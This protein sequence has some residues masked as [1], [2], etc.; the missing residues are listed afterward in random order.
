[1]GSVAAVGTPDAYL[2]EGAE[3]EDLV[4]L[5]EQRRP[6]RTLFALLYAVIALLC[7]LFLPPQRGFE[8]LGVVAVLLFVVACQ[9]ELTLSSGWVGCQQ[10]AFMLMLFTLPLNAVPAL[11]C[12]SVVVAQMLK[13]EPISRLGAWIGCN[14]YA[15]PPV[16]VLALSGSSSQPAWS[17]WPTYALAFACQ[18]LFSSAVMYVQ[19]DFYGEHTTL[20]DLLMPTAVDLML[21]PIGLMAAVDGRSTPVAAAVTL[22]GV[23]GLLALLGREHAERRT[24]ADRAL[25]DPLTGLPNRALFSEELDACERRCKRD[26]ASAGVVLIDLDNFKETNDT[27][28]HPCGDEVLVA[29]A[30]R[31][32]AAVR[33]VDTPARLGGDE[34]AVLLAG[35]VNADGV[36]V[37]AAKL[38]E[39]LEG[40]ATLRGGQTVMIGASIGAAVL[41][42]EIAVDDAMSQADQRL[43][44]D[45]RHRK[46]SPE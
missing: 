10:A 43:Y 3:R 36:S 27:L 44:A 45:K 37:V 40:P 7:M 18:V 23:T 38:R 4:G 19:E 26:G 42:V 24:Q 15:V 30:E 11:A 31:L 17:H 14:W 13:R 2:R 16:L 22:T 29:F 28:G 34:F 9:F 39:T 21:T 25:R 32:R 6:A 41:G 1:M 12:V 35:P 33:A 8:P 46:Q 5:R 20:R